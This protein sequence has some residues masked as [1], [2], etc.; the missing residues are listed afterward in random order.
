MG[1]IGGQTMKDFD[2]SRRHVLDWVESPE[3]LATVQS[4]VEPQGLIVL[5]SPPWMPRSWAEPDESKLF[6]PSSRFL[7]D[8]HRE[9]LRRWWLA[10]PRGANIP[11]WDLILS[12]ATEANSPAL[13]LI[14]AKAHRQEFDRHGKP[15][16]GRKDRDVTPHTSAN[17]DRIGEAIEEASRALS[18]SHPGIAISRD[19]HYQLSDRIAMSWKLASM[20]I[21]TALI[22]VGFLGDKEI[23]RAG[24]HFG[25]D[26]HWQREFADYVAGCFPLALL[27]RDIA[28]G[29]A[30]FR[31]SARSLP[32]KRA[33]RT[34]AERRAGRA[35]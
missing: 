19:R 34:L 1:D 29:S 6:E 33:S 14:E 15:L 28:C 21:P 2:G 11:N 32:I 20:G 9:T 26:D 13:V 27:D 22:F 30:A 8:P 17:H 12:A 16:R 10:H 4:W 35:R 31:V 5:S 3:F 18:R 7:S 23:A 24:I 25:D